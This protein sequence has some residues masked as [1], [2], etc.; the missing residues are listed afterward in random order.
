MQAEAIPYTRVE[1]TVYQRTDLLLRADDSQDNYGKPKQ[2]G[3]NGSSECVGRNKQ[4]HTSGTQRMCARV[5]E[6]VSWQ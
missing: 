1:N 3:E 5:I 4:I 6:A 2:Q